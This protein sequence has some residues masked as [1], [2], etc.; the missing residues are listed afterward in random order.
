MEEQGGFI[1]LFDVVCSEEEKA[2]IVEQ[3]NLFLLMWRALSR[4]R[5]RT[6]CHLMFTVL[7]IIPCGWAPL[8]PLPR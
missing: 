5:L 2:L 8:W 4:K 7:L 1:K 6:A 3:I